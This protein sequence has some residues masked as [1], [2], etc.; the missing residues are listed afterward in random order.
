MRSWI[1]ARNQCMPTQETICD[2]VRNKLLAKVKRHSTAVIAK[3]FDE[4]ILRLE[5][6]C[7]ALYLKEEKRVNSEALEKYFIEEAEKNHAKTT[8]EMAQ[9]IGSKVRE[10]DAFFLSLK[11]ARTSKAGSTFETNLKWL[12]RMLRYPFDEK[13]II[14]GQPDFLLP[15]KEAYQLHAAD[16]II[17]TA[18]RT[19]RERWRQIVTEGTRGR[20]FYLATLD[21]KIS[22]NQIQ[23]M[24]HNRIHV[25]IP[26][27]I[28]EEVSAYR[29]PSA[30]NVI[31][32]SDFFKYHLDPAMKRWRKSGL[33]K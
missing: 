28:L 31:S 25:V 13:V 14:N 2:A 10:L 26:K 3:N 9:L 12:F 20:G 21:K 7:Y 18:K 1:Q 30:M 5:K 23:E 22:R 27:E 8:A 32:F 29:D 4:L 6:E 11:Q 17:F 33:L 16:C 24:K 15:S 19:L